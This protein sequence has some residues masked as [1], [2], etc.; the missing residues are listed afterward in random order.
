MAS[1][2]NLLCEAPCLVYPNKDKTLFLEVGFSEHCVSA[3]LYQKYDQDKRVVAYVSKTLNPAEHKYSDCDKALLSTVWEINNSYV[4][5]QKVI[6]SPACDLSEK[7]T[8]L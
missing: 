3:G 7:P 5:G 2:K 8:N 1:L 4:G 6:M